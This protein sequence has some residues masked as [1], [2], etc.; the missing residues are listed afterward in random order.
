VN[1]YK[2]V[3]YI[4]PHGIYRELIYQTIKNQSIGMNGFMGCEIRVLQPMNL[5]INRRNPL[6]IFK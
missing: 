4:N 5:G 6:T 1:L 3:A 2:C